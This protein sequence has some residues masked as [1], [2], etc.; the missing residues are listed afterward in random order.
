MSSVS[1]LRRLA[2]IEGVSFLILLFVAMPLKYVWK[3]PGA[4]QVVGW[5][6]GVLFV[7]F[8]WSLLQVMLEKNWPFLRACIVF[9]ASLLPFG[10]FVLDK[11]MREWESQ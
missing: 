9:I 10:P 7:L 5:V 11:K 1:T 8:C 2:L 4:V 6:H 3:M